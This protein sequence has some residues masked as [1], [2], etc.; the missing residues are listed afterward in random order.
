MGQMVDLNGVKV[1]QSLLDAHA[2]TEIVA[3]LRSVAAVA[4]FRQYTTPSGKKMS[5]KMTGAGQLSWTSDRGGY[6][7][8]AYQPNGEGWPQIPDNILSVWRLASD[9]EIEPDA[10]LV[11]FYD[12]GAKM[13]MHQDRDEE[14][15]E[16]PV[17]SISLGDDALFRVGG[18]RRG[19]PT[20]SM[21]LRSGDV[22]VLAGTSRLA[23]HGIDRIKFGS[24]TLLPKAGRI[25]V[26][27][28]R[29]SEEGLTPSVPA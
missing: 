14:N 26:T 5:V 27:L 8:T 25:N 19:G 9:A 4:P 29:V 20:K 3:A 11:N 12:E 10:C 18:T 24:S 22:A 15:F 21:W 2:Q 16:W 6:R 28:R 1:W 17:V 23:Y 7:Y 13:G